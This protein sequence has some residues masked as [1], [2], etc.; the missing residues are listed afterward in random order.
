[1]GRA[2]FLE[3]RVIPKKIS[4]CVLLIGVASSLSWGGTAAERFTCTAGSSTRLISIYRSTDEADL[5]SCRVDYTKDGSTRTVWSAN[6]GYAFCIKR[7]V[8]LVTKLTR[9]NYS[10]A[11]STLE[12]DPDSNG[13]D[14]NGE[15]R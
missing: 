13:P 3:V 8:E 2:S 15:T 12:Q 9:G 4:A 14:S 10:C 5:G 11:P 1:L 7:A 6:S